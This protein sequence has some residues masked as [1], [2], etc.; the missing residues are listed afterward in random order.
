MGKKESPRRYVVRKVSQLSGKSVDEISDDM[1]M[2][3]D[4]FDQVA[5]LAVIKFERGLNFVAVDQGVTVGQL[6]QRIEQSNRMISGGAD[7]QG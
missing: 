4:L 6:I 3:F 5:T 7:R 2:N 1:V